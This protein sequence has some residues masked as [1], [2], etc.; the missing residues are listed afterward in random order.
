MI[1]KRNKLFSKYK[2]SHLPELNEH[3]KSL[4]RDVQKEIRKSHQQYINSL[5]SSEDENGTFPSS[6]KKLWT[7]IKNLKKDNA[8]IPPLHQND[9][10]IIDSLQKAEIFDHH[11]K[12]VFTRE[13]LEDFPSKGSS[14]HPTIENVIIST[15]GNPNTQIT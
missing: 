11:F 9:V 3:Y 5:I 1:R 10:T 7:C 14:S 8:N 2:A 15:T 13:N 12:S 6:N 4:K